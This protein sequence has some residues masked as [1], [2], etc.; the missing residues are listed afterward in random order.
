[1]RRPWRAR[2]ETAVPNVAK[3][4]VA[5]GVLGVAVAVRLREDAIVGEEIVHLKLLLPPVQPDVYEEP[6]A[7]PSRCGSIRLYLRQESPK[8]VRDT[9]V[10][11]VVA[12]HYE[13]LRCRRTFRV[14]PTGI[15]KVRTSAR[16][17]GLSVLL[18]LLGMSYGAVALTLEALGSPLKKTA[19]YYAVQARAI[20]S[21]CQSTHR[22]VWQPNQYWRCKVSGGDHVRP[23][24]QGSWAAAY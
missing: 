22:L 1:M 20:R 19:V 14:Y 10:T 23:G 3:K 9:L 11:E 18:Y 13:C 4:T 16:L 17:K 24:E 8:R 12:R 5:P 15:S 21:E 7:C 2:S 6:N